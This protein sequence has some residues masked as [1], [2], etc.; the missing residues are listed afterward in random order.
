VIARITSAVGGPGYR[1]DPLLCLEL[2]ERQGRFR[3]VGRMDRRRR[4]V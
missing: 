3:A 4:S 2:A 1:P